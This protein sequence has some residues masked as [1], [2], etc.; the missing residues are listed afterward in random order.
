MVFL[1]NLA[2][3][4]FAPLVQPAAADFDVTAASL[5]VVTSAAWLGSATPRLPTGYLLTR[6]PRHHVIAGTGVLL[7]GTSLFTAFA[8]SV[9]HLIV[10]AFLMGLSSGVYFIAANPL[11]SEL[12]PER[13]GTAIGVHGMSSQVAAVLAPLVLSAILFVGDWRTTFLCVAAVAA[14][15]TLGLVWAARRTPL[16]DAGSEDRSL[17]VAGRAQWPIILTGIAFVGVAGFLWNGLFNLY[18]DYLELTKGIGP[19]TGRLLLS[20]MFAAGVPAF[21]ISGRLADSVPNVPLIIAIISTFSVSVLVLTFV[22]GLFAIALVSVVIGYVIHSLF[23]A[24][25]TYMLSALPDHHRASAYALFS[26][27]MMLVQ[28][29]GSGTVGTAVSR[30][31]GYDATFRVLSLAVVAMVGFMFVLYRLGWLPSGGTPGETPTQTPP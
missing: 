25:D 20:L 12:F 16:P 10:G 6:F 1:V 19:G 14:L 23:P 31:A 27:S 13:V 8:G 18:G 29:F 24:M 15:S 9:T 5:G 7:V 11:V 3:I 4:V 26:A 2:R 17:L 22:N 21:F 30:G 28:A